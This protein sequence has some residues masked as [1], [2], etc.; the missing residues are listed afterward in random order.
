[1]RIIP[2]IFAVA[3]C[4]A[5]AAA[6]QRP[7]PAIADAAVKAAFP[8]APADWAPRLTGDDTMAAVLG[9]PE[10]PAEERRG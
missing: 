4:A 3:L 10:Q 9:F 2:T 8:A 6:Q 7:D 5:P 1:M